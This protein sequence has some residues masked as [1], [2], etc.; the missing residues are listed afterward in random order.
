MRE[1]EKV[2]KEKYYLFLFFVSDTLG[3]GSRLALGSS[4]LLGGS[5]LAS[6]GL[7]ASS[8]LLAGLASGLLS[9]S[10][11]AN[12]LL[13]SSGLGSTLALVD[14]TTLARD[15]RLGDV[16]DLHVLG[17]HAH[18]D[19]H[20]LGVSV[21]LDGSVSDLRL[22]GDVVVTSLTLLLLELEG[23]AV[24]GTLL[25]T[26]H[27][28]SGEAS[29][30]VAETLGGDGGN[31]GADSLVDV[32]VESE[33]GVVLLDDGARSSLDGLCANTAHFSRFVVWSVF[34]LFLWK[35]L[36]SLMKKEKNIMAFLYVMC[37]FL[38]FFVSIWEK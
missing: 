2:N 34:S 31:L 21:D 3:K 29:D 32:K 15:L 16:V 17:E 12:N 4:S 24:D 10:L 19:E 23:D 1:R 6:D 25:D 13:A 7:L 30:L 27:E 14:A 9:A 26:L 33:A 22:L 11:L 20:S 8:R 5:L 35:N 18:G 28:V 37:F 38:C 36:L